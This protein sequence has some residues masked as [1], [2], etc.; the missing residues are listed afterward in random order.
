MA[1]FNFQNEDGNDVD[2]DGVVKK[3]RKK[4]NAGVTIEKNLNNIN[5]S[6]F[7]LVSIF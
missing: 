2:G 7:D 5:L 3:V 1:L 4:R 6:K